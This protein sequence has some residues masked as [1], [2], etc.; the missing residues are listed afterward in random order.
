MNRGS[1]NVNDHDASPLEQEV[2]AQT[3]ITRQT[4][5]QK[6]FLSILG[7][8]RGRRGHTR[9]PENGG[10]GSIEIPVR[11]WLRLV[12][13]WC[14]LADPRPGGHGSHAQRVGAMVF[15]VIGIKMVSTIFDFVLAYVTASFVKARRPGW[16]RAAFVVV[17]FSP[18]VLMNSAV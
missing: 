2:T 16:A 3:T 1:P 4:G 17:L 10:Q 9:Y 6:S 11:R 8:A 14:R 12:I 7:G 5:E 18:P 13:P 15:C